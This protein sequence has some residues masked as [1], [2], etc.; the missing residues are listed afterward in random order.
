[1]ETENI[2]M[3]LVEYRTKCSLYEHTTLTRLQLTFEQCFFNIQGYLE[4]DCYVFQDARNVQNYLEYITRSFLVSCYSLTHQFSHVVSEC[5]NELIN[6]IVEMT[7][8]SVEISLECE[9]KSNV[10]EYHED[11][12]TLVTS[13]S[14][15]TT[16]TMNDS[17]IDR[18]VMKQLERKQTNHAL[19]SHVGKQRHDSDVCNYTPRDNSEHLMSDSYNKCPSR[20]IPFHCATFNRYQQ[21][22]CLQDFVDSSNHSNTLAPPAPAP[23]P[24]P[25]ECQESPSHLDSCVKRIPYSSRRSAASLKRRSKKKRAK[26]ELRQELHRSDGIDEMHQT[27]DINDSIDCKQEREAVRML[28]FLH[29]IYKEIIIKSRNSLE[30]LSNA[31]YQITKKKHINLKQD[32]SKLE[33]VI[34]QIPRSQKLAFAMF[35]KLEV[36]LE[37]FENL[38]QILDAML[39]VL[40]TCYLHFL[41]YFL[42]D[43][44]EDLLSFRD[45]GT[46]LTRMIFLK[47]TLEKIKSDIL[48]LFIKY[49]S[50]MASFWKK[51]QIKAR[52]ENIKNFRFLH[53]VERLLNQKGRT[54]EIKKCS[55]SLG[56]CS[57]R[58]L[59]PLL[60]KICH[61]TI[62]WIRG[63]PEAV[64]CS[65]FIK[66]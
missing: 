62:S 26:R 17:T 35:E 56:R 31:L 30:D 43:E 38:Q 58:L 3:F 21:L 24:N 48:P 55:C 18:L 7:S 57:Q 34:L 22:E 50:S 45:Q 28:L 6:K 41:D 1:M 15:S 19:Q 12:E 44:S 2:L 59:M 20:V 42:G 64:I 37:S 8:N 14:T 5:F 33:D 40:K 65:R 63:S 47:F 25:K 66:I 52:S 10:P 4:T 61:K 46:L 32:I 39:N 54:C 27:K 16:S 23:N 13:T 29:Y 11:K 51:E 9:S 60:D 49:Q 53:F 36:S